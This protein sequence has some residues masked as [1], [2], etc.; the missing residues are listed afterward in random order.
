MKRRVYQLFYFG[1]TALRGLLATPV[2]SGIAV[3][4]IGVTLLLVGAFALLLRNMQALVDEFGDELRVTAYLEAELDDTAQAEVHA[5]VAAIDGVERVEAV[6]AEEALARFQRSAGG[7]SA[8]LEGLDDNPLPASLEIALAPGHQSPDGLRAV[9]ADLEQVVGIEDTSSGRDWVEGYLRAIAVVR[10]I[11]LVLGAVL[12]LAAL[13]IVA[14]T[15]RL[16]VYARRDELEILSL[17]GASRTFVRTPFLFEGALQGA[18]GGAVALALLFGLYRLVLPAF[19]LG[20]ELLVGTTPSFFSGGEVGL[21]LG[22]GAGL[23]LLG[24]GFALGSGAA[25]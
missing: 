5:R 19:A 22:C 23:G 24:S 25:P 9:V 3:A 18:A 21:L 15:I 2:T 13:L 17:V 7:A 11:A 6:S 10:G 4:T 1:R 8:L 16:G 12:A 20:L 14:N